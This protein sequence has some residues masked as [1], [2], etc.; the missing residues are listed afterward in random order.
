MIIYFGVRCGMVS[1]S[2]LV[3]NVRWFLSTL[4]V[5]CGM[6]SGMVSGLLWCNMW[7]AVWITSVILMVCGLLV[8]DGVRFHFG[9]KCGMVPDVL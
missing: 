1:G 8:W 5:R 3:S 9:V 6:G 2:R 7:D 4:G